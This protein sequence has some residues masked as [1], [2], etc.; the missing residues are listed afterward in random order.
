[1][2]IHLIIFNNDPQFKDIYELND[3]IYLKISVELTRTKI[4]PN[5]LDANVIDTASLT[6]IMV[7]IA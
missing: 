3:L 7:S 5:A 4:P 6:A 2:P 1:M